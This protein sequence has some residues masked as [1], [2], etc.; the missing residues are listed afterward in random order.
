MTIES[1]EKA[2]QQKKF[3][4]LQFKLKVAEISKFITV[5]L[6]IIK[7]Y[8]FALLQ[9]YALSLVQSC[10]FWISPMYMG[11]IIDI[12]TRSKSA[13][14]L[15]S[16]LRDMTIFTLVSREI[17]TICAK[18][19]DK[20][21]TALSRNLKSELYRKILDC[22]LE[23]FDKTSPDE[24]S[25]I[26]Q[27]GM[28]NF[29][30]L[31][32]Y[33]S[34]GL[35][36][37]IFGIFGNLYSMYLVSPELAKIILVTLPIRFFLMFMHMFNKKSESKEAEKLR[38]LSSAIWLLPYEA[39]Q[40]I[41][42]VKCFSTEDK[43]HKEYVDTQKELKE[44]EAKYNGEP[45]YIDR[46]RTIIYE[47]LN[48]ILIYRGGQMVF[49]G[50]MTAGDLSMFNMYATT[51][52]QTVTSIHYN[53]QNFY[54]TYK[55]S[56]KTLK[57]LEKSSKA[58]D[59][60][61]QEITK[62]K[63]TG[64]ISVNN[65]SFCYPSKPE[66]KILHDLNLKINAGESVAFVGVSGSGKTTL[67][68]L[69]Q[70][71]YTPTEG[72]ILIDGEDIRDYDIKWLHQNTGYV[73]QEPVLLYKTIEQNIAYGLFEEYIPEQIDKALTLSNSKFIL[74][75][76]K[77]PDGLNTKIGDTK[78]SGGQKQRIAIARAFVKDPKILILDEPTS[79]LDGESES[80]VQK[81]IDDLIALGERTVI[82]IAHRLST[83]INCHKIVVFDEGKIVE[84]GTHKELLA[85]DGAYKKLF[86]FQ[87][88]SMKNL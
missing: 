87:I 56:E 4:Y 8:L 32:L 31:C 36:L 27:D 16:L 26:L 70:N 83:I 48:L 22:D 34:T 51:F 60:Q 68:Y 64:T 35:L 30:N 82:V 75:K 65:V 11:G 85:K 59:R 21:R 45:W 41:F 15:W 17:S 54:R 25:G 3:T 29:I 73:S 69:L 40:N 52:S 7:P 67:S 6:P 39:I 33:E 38:S 10:V 81:A 46:T 61:S 14:H 57:L 77:F 74:N 20:T 76:E 79:A 53:F 2:K 58:K 71:L 55:S 78:L 62:S 84:Q 19:N 37:S 13:D 63:L 88:N 47:A 42:L 1:D 50:K 23:F 9:N 49:D 86:E 5:V 43:E 18:V 24:A 66:I 12:V 44:I 28:E 72:R 80:K